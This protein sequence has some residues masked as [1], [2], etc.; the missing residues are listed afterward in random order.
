MPAN[1]RI[2]KGDV[3]AELSRLQDVNRPSF[4][5]LTE[6]APSDDFDPE[7]IGLVDI[8]SRQKN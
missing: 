4:R 3:E 2:T 5:V 6:Q 8:P 7:R 1:P